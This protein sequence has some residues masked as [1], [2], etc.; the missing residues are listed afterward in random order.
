MKKGDENLFLVLLDSDTA[1]TK[2][3]VYSPVEYHLGHKKYIDFS[4]DAALDKNFEDL[5]ELIRN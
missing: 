2:S 5:C 3:W 1:D 4:S